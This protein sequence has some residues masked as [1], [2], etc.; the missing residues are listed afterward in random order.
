MTFE[1]HIERLFFYVIE[2]N[3]YFIVLSF[4]LLRRHAI[5]INFEFNIFIMFSSF[6]LAHCCHFFVK[7]FD[8]TREKKTFLSLKKSQRV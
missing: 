1:N 7:I 2:L 5:D 6:C 4:F 8:I 3:Q